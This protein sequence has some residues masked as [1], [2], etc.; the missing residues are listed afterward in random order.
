MQTGF[1]LRL[2]AQLNQLG[3]IDRA[4]APHFG[5]VCHF[6]SKTSFLSTVKTAVSFILGALSDERAGPFTIFYCNS[7]ETPKTCR[8]M[9]P[10][11]YP[12]GTERPSYTPKQWVL[13]SFGDVRWEYSNPPPYGEHQNR[14]QS[15]FTTDG[16]S[17]SQYVLVSSTLVGL[18]TRYYFL[19]ECCCL[20]FAVLFLWGALC[21]ER[22]GLQLTV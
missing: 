13:F 10:Y 16:Q 6:G 3:P 4:T 7:F 2:Q 17:A 15:Y 21:D 18:A 14:S 11:L 9:F 8:A 5:Q 1:C 12:P 19:S 20:K 22:T